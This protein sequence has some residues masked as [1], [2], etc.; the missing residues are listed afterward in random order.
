MSAGLFTKTFYQ[1]DY[2]T[3]AP[4]HPIKVQPETTEATCG[5][6]TNASVATAT[7]N[8]IQCS[9]SR[10][11]RSIGLIARILY[12]Q[13]TGTPPTGYA[14]GSRT[15]IPALTTEFY[16]TAL[17]PE[18]EVNYLGTTWKVIGSSAEIPE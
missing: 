5:A 1:A 10:G 4:I 14:P 8:P 3:P 9:V 2:A 16:N 18:A 6:A 17:Q 12:L 7:T 13:L 11:R 15:K